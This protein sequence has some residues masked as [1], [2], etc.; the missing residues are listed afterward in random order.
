MVTGVRI[1][2]TAVTIVGDSL[3]FYRLHK[4]AHSAEWGIE[5]YMPAG[6]HS[7]QIDTHK[8]QHFMTVLLNR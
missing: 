4:C 6:A 2:L 3:Q 5:E 8:L 7:I 1:L